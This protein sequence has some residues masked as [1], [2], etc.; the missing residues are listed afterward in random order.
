MRFSIPAIPRGGDILPTEVAFQAFGLRQSI[1][2]IGMIGFITR[3]KR[4]KGGLYFG[5][6]GWNPTGIE[7]FAEPEPVGPMPPKTLPED[8]GEKSTKNI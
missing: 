8:R 7:S 2:N 5:P 4:M 1:Y 3:R 6:A